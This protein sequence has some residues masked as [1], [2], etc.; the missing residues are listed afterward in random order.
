VDEM[1]NLHTN[2]PLNVKVE[3]YTKLADLAAD[4]QHAAKT[5]AKIISYFFLRFFLFFS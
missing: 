1:R 2:T 4:F 5:Y 3:V